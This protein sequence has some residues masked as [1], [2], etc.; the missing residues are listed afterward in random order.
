[1]DNREAAAALRESVRVNG[2][3][4]AASDDDSDAERDEPAPSVKA[5]YRI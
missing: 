3:A 4:E 2:R 5:R 1:M